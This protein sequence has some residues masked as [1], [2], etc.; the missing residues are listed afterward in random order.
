MYVTVTGI[1]KTVFP[2]EL[3]FISIVWGT[4]ER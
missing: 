2:F 4:E 3:L 1:Y